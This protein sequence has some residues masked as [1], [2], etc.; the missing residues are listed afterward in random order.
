MLTTNPDLVE[1]VCLLLAGGIMTVLGAWLN[2]VRSERRSRKAKL[3]D[4]YIAWLS[5]QSSVLARLRAYLY[6]AQQKDEQPATGLIE[7]LDR[8]HTEI[9]ALTGALN[10][11]LVYES[12]RTRRRLIELQSSHSCALADGVS[13][14]LLHQRLY[15]HFDALIRAGATMEISTTTMERELGVVAQEVTQIV[16]TSA[17]NGETNLRSE[18]IALEGRMRAQWAEIHAHQ[19]NVLGL[20]ER[21]QSFVEGQRRELGRYIQRLFQEIDD[22]ED[23]TAAFRRLVTSS[24]PQGKGVLSDWASSTE[25]RRERRTGGTD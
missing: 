14:V 6:L 25:A 15:H 16:Q 12:D 22:M 7:A 13:L 2:D 3:E 24:Y 19:N 5:S 8:V 20:R 21:T 1:K 9:G 10:T 23:D 4:A 11:A 17:D 18:A